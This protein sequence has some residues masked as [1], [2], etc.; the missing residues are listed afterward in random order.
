MTTIDSLTRYQ[1][2]WLTA[3]SCLLLMAA[4]AW[5]LWKGQDND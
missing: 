5:M 3:I 1:F 2:R 4:C